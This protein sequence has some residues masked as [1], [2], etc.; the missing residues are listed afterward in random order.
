[1]NAL[2]SAE[3]NEPP[4]LSFT[5]RAAATI[6]TPATDLSGRCYLP[7]RPHLNGPAD[8]Q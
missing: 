1:M 8:V 5:S 3:D 2:S 7:D 6:T 4:T